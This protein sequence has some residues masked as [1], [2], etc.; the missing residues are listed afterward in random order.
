[1]FE[2]VCDDKEKPFLKGRS[3]FFAGVARM[4]KEFEDAKLE[5]FTRFEGLPGE[6]AQVEA[7]ELLQS[8]ADVRLECVRYRLLP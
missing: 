7:E 8:S 6:Y 5:Q 3:A 2:L 1:M 4:R